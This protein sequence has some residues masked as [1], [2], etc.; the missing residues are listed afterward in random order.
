MKNQLNKRTVLIILFFVCLTSVVG[1]ILYWH[2]EILAEE[3]LQDYITRLRNGGF[4]VEERHLTD[5]DV[6]GIIP[7]HFFGDFHNFA[8]QKGINHIYVDRKT[9]ALFFPT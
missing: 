7:I 5:L 1:N 6:D 4:T 3:K 9:G 2:S 8:K